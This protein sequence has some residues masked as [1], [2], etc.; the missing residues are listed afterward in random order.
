[1]GAAAAY[2]T[3][4]K[5]SAAG[6]FDAGAAGTADDRAIL[7]TQGT[8]S[9]CNDGTSPGVMLYGTVISNPTVVI[10]GANS[11]IVAD[12]ATRY[13]LSW[14]RATVDLAKF[15]VTGVTP[16]VTDNGD[17]TNTESWTMP[18][19][20]ATLT[21]DGAKVIGMLGSTYVEGL[22]LDSP[23]ISVTYPNS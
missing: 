12:V 19:A 4:P 16:T 9:I 5:S 11:R 1:M 15:D 22:G 13:R 17:G 10:D 14:V 7:R 2:F 3:W 20:T 8:V 18:S 6:K 23:T 21:A